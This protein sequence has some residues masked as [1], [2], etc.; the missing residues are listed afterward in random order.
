MN[1]TRRRLL[2]SMVA[3]GVVPAVTGCGDDS[4]STASDG[5]A[6]QSVN[7]GY[8][9]G[10]NGASIIALA[11]EQGLWEKYGLKANVKIFTNGPLQI[12][13]LNTGDLDYGYI[14]PGALWLPATG[15]AKIIAVNSVTLADRV[16][17]QPGITSV[18]A[19]D[20]KTVGI[21]EGT[22]GDMILRLALDRANM[23]IDDV[24][25]VA[26]DASTVVTAFISGQIDAAGIWYPLVDTIKERIPDLVEVATS[27]DFYPLTTFPS[28]FVARNEL[29]QGNTDTTSKMIKV[30]REANDYRESRPDLTI[31]TAAD[32]LKVES[33]NLTAESATIKLFKSADLDMKTSDGTIEAWLSSV[34]KLF[35]SFG[36]LAEDVDPA[37]YYLGELYQ[38]AG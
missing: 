34:N 10:Y 12:Q 15:K 38:D 23:T 26:M 22:S 35:L 31:E 29:A 20:G 14:G 21:P 7:I 4:S 27:E 13:A 2:A 18:E 33:S 32:Y 25:I 19:L 24:E 28:V 16:I 30:I 8:M 36:K 6:L 3:A 17:A 9:T 5:T 37:S 11:E 1:I